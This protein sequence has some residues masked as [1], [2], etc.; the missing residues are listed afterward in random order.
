M[1]AIKGNLIDL[2]EA[3]R[4][5]VIVHGCNCFH[6][7]GAGIAKEISSR[8]PAALAVDKNSTLKGDSSKL[9]GYTFT[10]VTAPNGYS[11]IIVNAYTQYYYGRPKKGKGP[12]VDYDAIGSV[13][14]MIAKHFN[15]YRIGYPKIGAGLAGGNWVDI[16]G[17][18]CSKLIGMDHQLVVL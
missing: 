14:G 12:V 10:Y 18:I 13:F 1:A 6:A 16:N 8:Y 15:S 7:M 9:G 11:F 17:I 3:G 4:F 5:D 2:A